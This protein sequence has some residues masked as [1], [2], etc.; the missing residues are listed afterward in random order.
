LLTFWIR[1]KSSTSTDGAGINAMLAYRMNEAQL[2]KGA[3]F[4][5]LLLAVGC[6]GKTLAADGGPGGAPSSGDRSSSGS[7]SAGS[8]AGATGSTG[9]N[10][11]SAGAFAG[12]GPGSSAGLPSSGSSSGGVADSGEPDDAGSTCSDVLDDP[13]NCGACGH[14]CQGAACVAGVCGQAPVVLASQQSAGPIA[15]DAANV[16]WVNILPQPVG[17]AGHSQVM[18]CGLTG[19]SDRPSILW[20]GLYPVNAMVVEQGAAWWPTGAGGFENDPYGMDPNILSCAV[21]GCANQPM[22]LLTLREDIAGFAADTQRTY[23]VTNDGLIQ[24]CPLA[25]CADTPTTIYSD[26]YEVFDVAVNSTAVF[27]VDSDAAIL[28]CPS[29]G[30]VGDPTAIGIVKGGVQ[31]LVADDQNVYWVE[32]GTAVGGG[33]LGPVTRWLNGAVHQCAA[34]GCNGAPTTLATYTSWLGSSAMAVDGTDVYWSAEDQSGRY[35]NIMRCTIGGCATPT[36]VAATI[37][38]AT[39]SPYATGTSG[40]AVDATRIYWSDTGRGAIMMLPK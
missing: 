4:T 29:T 26:M 33:K 17:S 1:S 25:G 23:F 6:G 40:L 27:W 12:G 21:G 9:S 24:S 7:S 20:D 15:I 8:G 19:C 22:S 14:D 35:S 10:G 2:R 36:V 38:A 13:L 16:Y 11:N 32:G 5:A 28:S 18:R 34:A 31:A 3:H 39:G 37:P 30:C